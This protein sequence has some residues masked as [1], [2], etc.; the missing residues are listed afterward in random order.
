MRR[1]IHLRGDT[2]QLLNSTFNLL[3]Y[4]TL[5]LSSVVLMNILLMHATV[6]STE[7]CD[8]VYV[9]AVCDALRLSRIKLTYEQRYTSRRYVR[10][11]CCFVSSSHSTKSVTYMK[12]SLNL[13]NNKYYKFINYSIVIN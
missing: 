4:L 3:Y 1:I 12:A 7:Q 9:V 6:S 11:M 8:C 5:R 2:F 13:T 10:G